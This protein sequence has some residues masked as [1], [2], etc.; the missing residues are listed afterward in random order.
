MFLLGLRVTSPII[1]PNILNNLDSQNNTMGKQKLNWKKYIANPY[2]EGKP[3][4]LHSIESM[5]G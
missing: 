3:F 4:T 5:R 1:K 2:T